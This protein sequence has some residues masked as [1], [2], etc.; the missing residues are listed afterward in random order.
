[1]G[2]LDLLVVRIL[3]VVEV[4]QER[5]ILMG[6]E[7]LLPLEGLLVNHVLDFLGTKEIFA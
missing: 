1:V 2:S 3:Q 4:W 7:E 5:K 6:G